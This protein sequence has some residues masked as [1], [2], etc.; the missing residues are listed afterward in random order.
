MESSGRSISSSLRYR[1]ATCSAPTFQSPSALGRTSRSYAAVN[2]VTWSAARVV[3]LVSESIS[4]VPDSAAKASGMSSVSI[5]AAARNM[6]RPRSV[7]I[8][9]GC[10]RFA[11][12]A[13]RRDGTSES[14]AMSCRI[15]TGAG[16]FSIVMRLCTPSESA[17]A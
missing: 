1:R 3:A 10:T 9:G 15:R 2:S 14:L 12:A 11:L 6:P 5:A 13:E 7:K 16:A 17:A 4:G 8:L